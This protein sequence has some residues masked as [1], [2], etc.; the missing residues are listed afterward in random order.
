MVV[1]TGETI[2]T[3]HMNRA[4]SLFKRGE[5]KQAIAEY[6]LQNKEKYSICK[7]E[8]ACT[9]GRDGQAD[10][11]F[12]Y[13]NEN[14]RYD[15]SIYAL[16]NPDFLFIRNDP[17][18]VAFENRW[19][20]SVLRY[21]PNKIKD[22]PLAK[23][24]WHMYAL[25]QAYF[26]EMKVLDPT[27]GDSSAL[28][29]TFQNLKREINLENERLLDSIVAVKGWP[30]IS[31]VGYAASGAAFLIV[32]HAPLATQ[33]KYLPVIKKR[34][35]EGEA[36]WEDYAHV[37]DRIQMLTNKPQLYG[38]QCEFIG[39]NRELRFYP[40]EDEA[41]VNKRRAAFGMRPIE[42]YAEMMG[43]EYTPTKK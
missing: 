13:L 43:F 9:Y 22:I 27:Y 5:V 35:E 6:R 40:V 20:D 24:L 19:I 17:R 38:T 23:K 21:S 25:D 15:T 41:E 36:Q 10:S 30:K 18:W 11:A 16:I 2:P 8:L 31:Q 29:S 4:D 32:Q 33:Q 37:Y 12:K 3:F 26:Y 42:E 7:D 34:C 1:S 39:P 28:M 14:L